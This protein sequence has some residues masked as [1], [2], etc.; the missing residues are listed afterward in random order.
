MNE[1]KVGLIFIAA[2]GYW[3]ITAPRVRIAIGRSYL[4]RYKACTSVGRRRQKKM[5][6]KN[7]RH[8]FY[9]YS[10]VIDLGSSQ[11]DGCADDLLRL[12]YPLLAYQVQTIVPGSV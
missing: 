8:S 10:I 7:V 1:T 4:P 2:G 11:H 6:H 12:Y 5:P 9:Y 3:P